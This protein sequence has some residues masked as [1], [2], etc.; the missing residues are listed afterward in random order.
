MP[1]HG[2]FEVLCSLRRI[3]KVEKKFDGMFSALQHYPLELIHIDAH[4]IGKYGNVEI[5]YA[6]AGDHIYLVVAYVNGFPL[7][8]WDKGMT[9]VARELNVAA[10]TP[11]EY[12]ALP[13]ACA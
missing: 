11:A 12:L 4:F 1:A 8:T 7:V 10:Y 5:P 2:W 6:K 3:E 13:D 9:N